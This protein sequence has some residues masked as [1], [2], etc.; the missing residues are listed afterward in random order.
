MKIG[1]NRSSFIQVLLKIWEDEDL[2]LPQK[3]IMNFIWSITAHKDENKA[4]IVSKVLEKITGLDRSNVYRNTKSLEDM[5]YISKKMV[6]TEHSSHKVTEYTL[7]LPYLISKYEKKGMRVELSTDEENEKN[8][9]NVK[10]VEKTLDKTTQK[11]YTYM[12]AEE[13]KKKEERER[14]ERR[15]YSIRLAE[16]RNKNLKNYPYRKKEN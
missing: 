12:S 2:T 4:I 11:P 9:K 14:E 8:I 3:S 15:A 6:N 10:K 13:K 16:E 5:G 1:Q 7:N